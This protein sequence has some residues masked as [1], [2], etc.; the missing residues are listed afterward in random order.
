MI[1]KRLRA[2]QEFMVLADRILKWSKGSI[3]K[4]ISFDKDIAFFEQIFEPYND[5][6]HMY[7]P[8]YL[9]SMYLENYKYITPFCRN[10]ATINCPCLPGEDK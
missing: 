2:G 10:T 3:I 9:Y 1:K 4:C 5:I 7:Q 6:T 8:Y